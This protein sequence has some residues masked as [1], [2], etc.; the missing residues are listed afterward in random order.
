VRDLAVFVRRSGHEARVGIIG[1]V[2]CELRAGTGAAGGGIRE[3]IIRGGGI[4]PGLAL[5]AI[6]LELH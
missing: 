5:A 6:N 4:R 1:R 2:C 3:R